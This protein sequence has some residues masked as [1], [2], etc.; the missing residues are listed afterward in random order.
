M[1]LVNNRLFKVYKL[2][3][4]TLDKAWVFSFYRIEL[5]ENEEVFFL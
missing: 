2:R 3:L 4:D 5:G 1:M